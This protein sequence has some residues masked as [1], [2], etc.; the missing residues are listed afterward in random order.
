ME[1]EV[2]R[3]EPRPEE[4]KEEPEEAKEEKKE[5]TEEKKEEKP[6]EIVE[7]KPWTRWTMEERKEH[8]KKRRHGPRERWFVLLFFS[9]LFIVFLSALSYSIVYQM[10]PALIV[11]LIAVVVIISIVGIFYTHNIWYRTE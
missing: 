4:K 11:T 3:E 2:A 8:L 10:D 6:K 5:K 7:R 1:E 9:I